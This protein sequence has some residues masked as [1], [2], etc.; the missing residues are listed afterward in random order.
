MSPLQLETSPLLATA[1]AVVLYG[2]MLAIAFLLSKL[3]VVAGNITTAQ[4]RYGFLDGFRGL[5]SV[6]VFIHHSFTAY[7]YFVTD[8]WDWSS[9]AIINHLGQTTVALFF[10]ITGF[11]FALKAL[12]AKMDWSAFYVLRLARL[13]PLYAIVV[14]AVFTVVFF[15]S[16]GIFHESIWT[17]AMEFFQ[18]LSFVCLGRPDINEFPMTWTLIAG[19]NWSLKYEVLFYILAV[20]ALHFAS[21][22]LSPRSLLF[23]S[24]GLLSALLAIRLYQGGG[25][26]AVLYITHFLCGIVAAYA[27]KEPRV[28]QVMQNKSFQLVA[29]LSVL[30]LAFFPTAYGAPAILITIALFTA[31]VGG[32]SMGGLLKLPAMLWL[33]DISYGIYLIHGLVLWLT[34]HTFKSSLAQMNLVQYG[35]LMVAV[36]AVA[37]SLASLSYIAVEK[38]A[39]AIARNWGKKH[40]MASSKS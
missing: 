29:A 8:K 35:L 37:I 21:K 30:G 24:L 36:G 26:G 38:P 17:I 31:V 5:L 39:M 10:M 11:L 20:P 1:Y 13:L 15:L 2:L 9:S 34:L 4:G 40:Q 23:V 27:Y 19:V 33:G 6:G 22:L 28:F 14:S 25:D 12:S 7:K 3:P 32:F 16:Q 18:W